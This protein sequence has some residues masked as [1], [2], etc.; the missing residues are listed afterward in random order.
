MGDDFLTKAL[1]LVVGAL[2][3]VLSTLATTSFTSHQ[4][5][6]AES[7][8]NRADARRDYLD[9]LRVAS[10]D[11]RDGFDR[12]YTRVILEKKDISRTPRRFW[13]RWID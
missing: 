6:K 9:P 13:L 11:L 10:K 1:L 12:A 3:G 2:T 4:N 8:K 5:R 7:R